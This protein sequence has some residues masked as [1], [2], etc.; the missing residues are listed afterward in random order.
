[1]RRLVAG[2]ATAL[3]SIALFTPGAGA[4]PRVINPTYGVPIANEIHI[5][6]A[7]EQ[8][9]VARLQRQIERLP[10][11]HPIT[12]QND[13]Y[14]WAIELLPFYSYEGLVDYGISRL[15]SDITFVV[16]PGDSAFHLLGQ[17]A[18][19]AD[20]KD[21]GPISINSRY[22]NPVSPMYGRDDALWTLT[23]ELQHMQGGTF[24]KGD[25]PT[26]ETNTQLGST[27]VMA[28]MVNYGNTVALR[29]FLEEVRDMGIG[30]IESVMPRDAFNVWFGNLYHHDPIRM[31]R[32]WKST[33]HWADDPLGLATILTKYDKAPFDAIMTG[34]RVGEIA[35]VQ[36]FGAVSY[37][38]TAPV[39]TH[40]EDFGD[41]QYL[42]AYPTLERLVGEVAATS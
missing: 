10:V 25:S 14:T 8:A 22:S 42:L 40:S 5:T 19:N 41:T 29:P 3:I 30:A 9:F 23:H 36:V 13:L 37:N 32:F 35:R 1:M 26:L 16:Y 2:V 4:A 33:R 11:V 15:P 20:G 39:Q 7:E 34:L 12:S 6:I 38:P 31:G 24:C 27:E 17:A 21:E 28:A 18:C